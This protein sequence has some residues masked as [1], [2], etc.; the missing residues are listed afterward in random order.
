MSKP[1]EI[2]A[3]KAFNKDLTCRGFQFEIGKTYEHDG[4]VEICSS[5]FHACT[6]PLDVLN[7]YDVTTSRFA[8]VKASGEIDR[9]VR[10]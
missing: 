1:K 3:Y 2:V 5:G 8:L 4:P 6:D 10:S 7:Y 9:N